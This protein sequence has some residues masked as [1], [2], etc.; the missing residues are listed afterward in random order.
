MQQARPSSAP[1]PCP[2]PAGNRQSSTPCKPPPNLKTSPCRTHLDAARGK[3][4]VE[5]FVGILHRQPRV[6]LLVPGGF[7]GE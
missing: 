2:L 6:G 7:E 1:T 5:A 4:V 3:G